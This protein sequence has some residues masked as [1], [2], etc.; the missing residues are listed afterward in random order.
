MGN[1]I[2]FKLQATKSNCSVNND[3]QKVRDEDRQTDKQKTDKNKNKQTDRQTE[4]YKKS[5]MTRIGNN[6]NEKTTNYKKDTLK[7]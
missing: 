7:F 6:Q 5:G 2:N 3:R 1:R 4:S